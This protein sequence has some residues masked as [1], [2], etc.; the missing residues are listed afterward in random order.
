MFNRKQMKAVELRH[1]VALLHNMV[2]ILCIKE[3]VAFYH[4]N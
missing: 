3:I 4:S 1:D 2:H